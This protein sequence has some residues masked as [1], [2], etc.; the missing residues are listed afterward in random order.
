MRL[1]LLIAL[2]VAI[3]AAV[4]SQPV[5]AAS[6]ARTV[7]CGQIKHGPHAAYTSMLTGKK[8]S[9]DTWTVFATGVPCPAAMRTAPQILKWWAKAKIGASNFDA[10]GFGCNKESDGRGSAGSAGCAYKGLSNIELIMTGSYTVAE[11]K[12]MF[13][14]R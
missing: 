3:G 10:N 13:F 9:G 14:I 4:A 1:R 6:Q 7:I 5:P 12:R 11:L 8:L 2:A